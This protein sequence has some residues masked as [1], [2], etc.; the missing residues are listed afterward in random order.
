MFKIGT[1]VCLAINEHKYTG[2]VV[3][4]RSYED[5]TYLIH[6]TDGDWGWWTGDRLEVLC[7]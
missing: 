7:K 1:L 4:I 2:V 3:D 5:T 6:F